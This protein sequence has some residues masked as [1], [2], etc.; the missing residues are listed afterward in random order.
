[1]D[2]KRAYLRKKISTEGHM[3]DA[4]G[5]NWFSI[6]VFDVSQGGLGFLS[7]QQVNPGSLR[8]VTVVLK[9]DDEA[10]VLRTTVKIAHCVRHTL[11][12]GYRIGSEFIELD[13][14][15]IALLERVV[16]V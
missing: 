2:E 10:Q 8:L 11:F 5:E 7:T 12:D 16:A 4:V 9:I 14:K 3:A 15:Q 1:V 6:K 13:F